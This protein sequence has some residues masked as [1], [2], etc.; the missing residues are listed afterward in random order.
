MMVKICITKTYLSS[1]FKELVG[2]QTE[3]LTIGSLTKK[4][5]DW[6]C[7]QLLSLGQLSEQHHAALSF[8]GTSCTLLL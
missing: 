4:I 7:G 6:V 1:D 3:L 8:G 2:L 5:N